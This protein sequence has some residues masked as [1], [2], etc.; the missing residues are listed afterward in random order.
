MSAR[1]IASSSSL[2]TAWYSWRVSLAIAA[3]LSWNLRMSSVEKIL[4]N[5]ALRSL[6]SQFRSFLNSPWASMEICIHCWNSMP[7][8]SWTLAVT[9]LSLVI[10]PSSQLISAVAGTLVVPVPLSFR[11]SCSGDL[12]IVYLVPRC[13]NSSVTNVCLEGSAKS[14]RS[15]AALLSSLVLPYSAYVIAL[16]I[17]V[18]PAPVSPVTRNS[19]FPPK[20]SKSMVDSPP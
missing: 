10:T 16:K 8:I 19:P 14:L 13:S 12:V 3:R 6:V 17:E 2:S 4:L 1:D 20:A 11:R 15:T 18:F 5:T 7:R 9:S